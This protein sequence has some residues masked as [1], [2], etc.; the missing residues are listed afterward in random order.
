MA[1]YQTYIVDLSVLF[2]ARQVLLCLTCLLSLARPEHIGA[3]SF[4]FIPAPLKIFAFQQLLTFLKSGIR[5]PVCGGVGSHFFDEEKT[6]LWQRKSLS[7]LLLLHVCW[8]R[9]LVSSSLFWGQKIPSPNQSLAQEV[10][11]HYGTNF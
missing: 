7:D 4:P 2:F 6:F 1:G 5:V 3:S 9:G 8:V 10:L 11:V